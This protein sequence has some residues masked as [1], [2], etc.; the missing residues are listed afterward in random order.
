MAEVYRGPAREIVGIATHNCA[1]IRT[2]VMNPNED[3]VVVIVPE[4]V[5]G[6]GGI[7]ETELGKILVIEGTSGSITSE[8]NLQVGMVFGGAHGS[9]ADQMV[10]IQWPSHVPQPL[11][12][13]LNEL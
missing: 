4:G 7:R 13:N 8:I 3:D 1:V 11:T 10:Q 9:G 12:Y 2:P 5:K 6:T